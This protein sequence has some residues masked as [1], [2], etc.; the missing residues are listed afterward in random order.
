MGE[1]GNAPEFNSRLSKMRRDPR[2]CKRNSLVG[3]HAP[4]RFWWPSAAA[5]ASLIV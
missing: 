5:L 1:Q 4:W 2:P 3:C